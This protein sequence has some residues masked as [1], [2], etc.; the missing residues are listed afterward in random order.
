MAGIRYI[1]QLYTDTQIVLKSF[2]VLQAE[3]ALPRQ[4][5]YKYLQLDHALEAQAHQSSMVLSAHPLMWE[6]FSVPH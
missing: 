1:S 5:F 6:E 4:K 2:S 3:F